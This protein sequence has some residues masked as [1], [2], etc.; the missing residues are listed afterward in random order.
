MISSGFN[1]ILFNNKSLEKSTVIS[2]VNFSSLIA[3]IFLITLTF[4]LF[5]KSVNPLDNWIASLTVIPVLKSKL[6]VLLTS[7]RTVM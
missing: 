7:P 6:S 3:V 5:A 2:F 4:Y 1:L